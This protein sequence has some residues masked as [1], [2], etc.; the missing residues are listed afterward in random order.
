MI[1]SQ[2]PHCHQLNRRSTKTDGKEGIGNSV[3]GSHST[4]SGGGGT[5]SGSVYCERWEDMVDDVDAMFEWSVANRLNKIEWLLLGSFRW[6]DL[7]HSEHRMQ[8]LR[9]LTSL[10]HAY[11]LLIGADVPLGNIQQHAWYLYQI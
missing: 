8:R 1:G 11:S 2:G 9:V 10:G 6:G 3:N 5:G 7:D 4:G